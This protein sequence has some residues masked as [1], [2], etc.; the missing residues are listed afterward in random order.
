MREG[1]QAMNVNR[2]ILIQVTAYGSALA[3]AAFLLQWLEYHM[4]ARLYTPELYAIVIAVG[5]AG[6]GVWVGAQLTRPTA[7][8]TFQRNDA[9]MEA[10]GVTAREFET[11]EKLAAGMTNKEIARALGVS[12]NTVKT[13]LANLYEKL[14]VK[15]RTE[16]IAQ[17]RT[18]AIIP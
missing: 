4:V 7:P 10:L 5:F 15:R 9:A 11:L 6:L 12:P 16:A 18:H 14:G 17:A 3:L 8:S 13:H 2:K 1:H